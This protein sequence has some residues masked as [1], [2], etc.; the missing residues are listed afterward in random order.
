MQGGAPMH[1]LRV[2]LLVFAAV[3]VAACLPSERCASIELNAPAKGLPLDDYSLDSQAGTFDRSFRP[4]LQRGDPRLRCC[5][6]ASKG[7]RLAG[8][9]A[10]PDCA[11]VLDGVEVKSVGKPFSGGQHEG[12]YF[13]QV[14]VRDGALVSVWG[15]YND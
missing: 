9:E 14:A 3:S 11:G 7:V 10:A 12:G 13:C 6:G 1:T 15:Q 2:F 4:T 5:F 8:C